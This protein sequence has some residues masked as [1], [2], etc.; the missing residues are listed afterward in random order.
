M[1][2]TYNITI[3]NIIICGELTE[4]QKAEIRTVL[5]TLIDEVVLERKSKSELQDEI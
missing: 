2:N 1:P 3:Q 4:T 5:N